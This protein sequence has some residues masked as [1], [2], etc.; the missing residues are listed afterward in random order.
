MGGVG[1]VVGGEGL[2]GRGVQGEGGGIRRKRALVCGGGRKVGRSCV[3]AA[4][5]EARNSSCNNNTKIKMERL[6][7][8]T[9]GTPHTPTHPPRLTVLLT[10]PH[11]HQDARYPLNTHPPTKTHGTPHTPTH[12]PRPR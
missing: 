2:W 8:K 4:Y 10:H 5:S 6:T 11:T 1:G 7:A 3:R 9:H 12:P